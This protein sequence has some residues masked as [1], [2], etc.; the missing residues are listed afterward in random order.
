MS[1]SKDFVIENGVLKKYIGE[2]GDVIIPEGVT[3]IAESAFNPYLNGIA[4][5]HYDGR[6]NIKS[7]VIP[8]GVIKI[9]DL[10]FANCE[11]LEKIIVPLSIAHI[12]AFAFRGT[13][14]QKNQTGMITLGSILVSY[15]GND[16]EI[17]IPDGI[18][19]IADAVFEKSAS[20]TSVHIPKTVTSIGSRAF[21]GC[22]TL[23]SIDIPNGVNDIGKYAFEKTHW[24]ATQKEEFVIINGVLYAYNGAC[25]NAVIPDIVTEIGPY[26]FGH[27]STLQS[28]II[29]SSVVKISKEA[30]FCC[31]N[32]KSVEIPEGV[33]VIEDKTFWLC[34]SL[35]KLSFSKNVYSIGNEAF[36]GCEKLK[37]LPDLSNVRHIGNKAFFGCSGLKDK[38]GRIIVNGTLFEYR[39]IKRTIDIYEDVIYIDP[40]AIEDNGEIKQIIAS[41]TV[42]GQVWS[43]LRPA[44]KATVA[45]DCL[46]N[47]TLHNEAKNYIKK[48]AEKLIPEIIRNND[49]EML[50]RFFA[51]TKNPEL[52]DLERYISIATKKPEALAFLLEYKA[53]LFTTEQV[54]QIHE[55]KIEKELGFKERTLKDWKEIFKLSV[56]DGCVRISGYKQKDTVIEIPEEIDG[57]PV[58]VIAEGTF[59]ANS[60][61]REV[62]LPDTVTE[63]GSN[64]FKG[65]SSLQ[66]VRMPK[67][68]E[69][70]GYSAFEGCSSLT[71]CDL[72]NRVNSIGGTVFKG[73][74]SLEKIKL[75]NNIDCI[76][77]GLFD[78]C[79][80]L[81]DV[82]IPDSVTAIY[83]YAFRNCKVLSDIRFPEELTKITDGAFTN[84]RALTEMH[85]PDKVESISNFAFRGCTKLV[86][87]RISSSA[88][89]ISSNAMKD[90]KKLT[91]HA[92]ADSYAE[93]YA[94][95]NNIPF[96]AE[97]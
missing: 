24:L 21:Y 28:V 63:I 82:V 18:T 75:P 54:E 40:S 45:L 31:K 7:V 26:A 42:F 59:K 6:K 36:Y 84:C 62:I 43:L 13:Q 2:G 68:L 48:N 79:T 29:P 33:T 93:Q 80:A 20:I 27:N 30:F 9:G 3:E 94:K 49:G 87:I 72:H 47:N 71:G 92:P 50:S 91:I 10:A 17:T 5:K 67:A 66:S 8:E 65:C 12:G 44:S 53:K 96:V 86:K 52:N 35:Q 83:D 81:T 73:C 88:E 37:K 61:I 38:S 64:A 60:T 89:N 56:K 57:K 55:D 32:L 70:I 11:N 46:K 77:A 23:K 22:T 39:N 51:F 58:T 14:W 25:A 78:G 16:I 41:D 4:M 19:V 1:D 15:V 34:H 69:T 97:G 95:E 74:S 76:C 90:C 85:L